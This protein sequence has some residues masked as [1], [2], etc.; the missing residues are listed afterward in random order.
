MKN[1][2]IISEAN[3]ADKSKDLLILE[4]PENK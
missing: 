3:K 1:N 2:W 4:K